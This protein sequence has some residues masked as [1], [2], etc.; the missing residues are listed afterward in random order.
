MAARAFR[1]VIATGLLALIVLGSVY[2]CLCSPARR[3]AAGCEGCCHSADAPSMAEK[4]LCCPATKSPATFTVVHATD[5][6][7]LSSPAAVPLHTPFLAPTMRSRY[8][9]VVPAVSFA[10]TVLRI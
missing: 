9:P 1:A 2:A 10:Q 4:P 8:A 5:V 3:L 7:T 6:G